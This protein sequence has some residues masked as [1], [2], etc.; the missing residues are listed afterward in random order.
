MS[1][2]SAAVAGS[3]V[4]HHVLVIGTTTVGPNTFYGYATGG[5]MGSLSNPTLKGVVIREI[6][7]DGST[8]AVSITG[9]L[10]QSF[11]RRITIQNGAG[12]VV[13]LDSSSASFSAVSNS[14]WSFASVPYWAAGDL[15]ETKTIT[16]HY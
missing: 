15:A 16:F 1:G 8:F 3:G 6:S 11:F 7:D 14:L 13:N 10:A 9:V 4:S 2:V 5:V 12:S